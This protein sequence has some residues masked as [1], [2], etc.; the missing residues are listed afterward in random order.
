MRTYTP[1]M[2]S[3][4]RPPGPMPRQTV[5]A[6]PR[7]AA[8]GCATAICSAVADTRVER[9]I[10]QVHNQ[11]R[12]YVQHGHDQHRSLDLW[13][14]ARVDRADGIPTQSWPR[15]HRLHNDSASHQSAEL[16]TDDR[17]HRSEGVL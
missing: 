17:H 9:C 2:H 3:P 5:A 10:D 1:T 14:I 13:E 4:T 6:C 8:A 16:Q 15:K 12:Q 11:V 7:L